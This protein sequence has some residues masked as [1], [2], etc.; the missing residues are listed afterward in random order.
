MSQRSTTEILRLTLL[1]AAILVLAATSRPRAWSVAAGAV[2]VALGE[3]VRIWAAG[4]LHKTHKLITSGPYRW[5][6]N[7]LYLG[8]LLILTGVGLMAWYGPWINLVV[9]GLG[10]LLFFAYYM[11]RK[12]RIEPARLEQVHGEA[13]RRYF[14]AVPALFPGLR[15]FPDNGER[16]RGERFRRN[17]EHWTILG[18]LMLIALF[19]VRAAYLARA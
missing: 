14:E 2:L 16:W 15:P 19:A 10:W 9:I 18:L 13:Y 17:R 4:H 3:S 5:T 7:P 8:R 1:F 6:R 12:E 11:P